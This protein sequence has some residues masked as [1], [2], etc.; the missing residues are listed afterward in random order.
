MREPEDLK[1]TP[2]AERFGAIYQALSRLD[3]GID[4]A[5]EE[6]E[7]LFEL[8]A[9][10]TAEAA[11]QSEQVRRLLAECEAADHEGPPSSQDVADLER[12][13]RAI[14]E[15]TVPLAALARWKDA[16]LP[17]P[18]IWRDR[19]DGQG[20]RDVLL[21][22]GEVALLAAPGGLGKS[23]LALALAYAAADEPANYNT[24]NRGICGFRVRRGAV[25]VVSYED[26]PARIADR[27]K[28]Y[29]GDQ[30]SAW[31]RIYLIERPGPLWQAVVEGQRGD[32]VVGPDW[33]RLWRTVKTVNASLVVIDPVSAALSDVSVSEA[34]PVR[35]FLSELT[36]EAEAAGVGVLLVAHDTKSARNAARAGGHPG[37]GMIAG[38]AA[39]YDGAR[40]V[41]YMRR[42]PLT[43]DRRAVTIEKA[44]Y[45]R[46]EWGA[47][48]SERWGEGRHYRGLDPKPFSR[49]EPGDF[50]KRAA[51]AKDREQENRKKN[52]RSSKNG[53]QRN[54]ELDDEPLE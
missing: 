18:V 42:D 3:Q 36:R 28:W 9:P 49:L 44:N 23:T 37:A 46:T 43:H 22:T 25:V 12:K 4:G 47:L 52:R 45:G 24:P 38:S 27:L 29:A 10:D 11:D 1:T 6:L 21:S 41:A 34:G 19:A 17:E 30:S 7:E 5:R 8:L 50:A 15:H 40:G 51:Q 16:P 2:E 35:M 26:A 53:K 39:W 32:S 13:A 14:L 20:S 31:N 54:N 33:Q 48:L